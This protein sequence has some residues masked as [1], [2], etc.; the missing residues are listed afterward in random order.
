MIQ[1]ERM[2]FDDS[3]GHEKGR[4]GQFGRKSISAS[5]CEIFYHSALNNKMVLTSKRYEWNIIPSYVSEKVQR[6]MDKMN[7]TIE[8]AKLKKLEEIRNLGLNP[9]PSRFEHT[10]QFVKILHVTSTYEPLESGEET[11]DHFALAGRIIALRNSGMFIDLKDGTAK[12]QLFSH[13]K[14]LS[15]HYLELLSLLDLGDFIGVEGRIRRT[16]RGEITLDVEKVSILSKSLQPLP[17][18]YH[19]IQNIETRYRHR[20][21][22]LLGNEESR[23]KFMQ[24]S[25]IIAQIRQFMIDEDFVEVETPVLHSMYGGASA[26][27]FLTHYNAIGR[28]M[29][30]RIALELHLKRTLIGGLSDK[31]FELGR[32]F[33]NEGVSTRHN[34]EFTMLEA[35][36]A[37][38]DFEDMMTLVEGICKSVALKLY[39]DTIVSYGDIMLNFGEPFKRV[40]MIDSVHEASG[41]NFLEISS[42]AQAREIASQFL[43]RKLESDLNWGEVIELLFEE[44]VEPF[45]I[46]PTHVTHFP[47]DISPLAKEIPEEPRLVERFE[48]YCNAWEIANAFSELNDPIEQRKRMEAQVEILHQRGEIDKQ[49]DEDFLMAL[50]AGMPPTG[51]LG[52]GIDRLVMLFTDSRAIRDVL[53]FPSLREPKRE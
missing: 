39:G 20:H 15:V 2:P 24:R 9:Y 40:S 25:Q 1:L 6:G 18:K 50:E 11:E 13:K 14:N 3:I 23:I 44:L 49:L 43:K 35:Y 52:V 31:I 33:R 12:I 22:D 7:T 16:G 34:P 47:K 30:L 17:E 4:K 53:L 21:L 48:T 29:Y 32:V 45:L 19:G 42:D 41:I 26:K 38:S 8:G 27:P 5:P 10:A 28:D 51:G 36:A 37:Y 46:Q